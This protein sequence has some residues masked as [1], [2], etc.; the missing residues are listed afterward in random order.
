[1]ATNDGAAKRYT[2][3]V[4]GLARER[5]ELERVGTDLAVVATALKNDPE[6]G[7]FFASPVIQRADKAAI[8]GQAFDGRVGEITLNLLLLLVRKRREA[9][10]PAIAEHYAAAL[11][12]ERGE[13]PLTVVSARLL[14]EPAL[15][16]LKERL[17]AI[18]GKQ[19]L[20]SQRVEPALIGGLQLQFGDRRYD[21][22]IDGR[23]TALASQLL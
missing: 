7:A 15:A 1:M 20:V 22:S 14:S 17:D 19:F 2:E 8:V 5:G 3:A 10:I 23:L 18:F 16:Q 9:L 11:R 4:F 6:V 13:T 21:G 12:D